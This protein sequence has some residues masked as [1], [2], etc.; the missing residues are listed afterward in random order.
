MLL[1]GRRPCDRGTPRLSRSIGDI[2][3]AR[4]VSPL[5]IIT[6]KHSQNRGIHENADEGLYR[7]GEE[8]RRGRAARR[9]PHGSDHGAWRRHRGWE[10]ATP[11]LPHPGGS[12]EAAHAAT[13]AYPHRDAAGR[14]PPR[15]PALAKPDI[16]DAAWARAAREA[17]AVW[18][19]R[20]GAD[21][22]GGAPEG[23]RCS[24]IL[25]TYYAR[26]LEDTGTAQTIGFAKR[27]IV[28]IPVLPKRNGAMQ[29]LPSR[30]ALAL[31][32]AAPQPA[33]GGTTWRRWKHTPCRC[34]EARAQANRSAGEGGE[35]RVEQG[36]NCWEYT[37][38]R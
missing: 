9:G 2:L 6:C 25:Q 37:G 27:L 23:R 38:G 15:H 26:T 7:Y 10:M 19:Q 29:P 21:R 4:S 13:T 31:H 33:P 20:G 28:V 11:S 14:R 22:G 18:Y 1:G 12:R 3:Y 8:S 30:P 24:C 16:T 35:E 5:G 36:Y 32:C 17:R 34:S